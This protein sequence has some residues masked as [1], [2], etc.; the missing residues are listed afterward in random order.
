[1]NKKGLVKNKEIIFR[2]NSYIDDMQKSEGWRS[3][4]FF[5]INFVICQILMFVFKVFVFNKIGYIRVWFCYVIII[6]MLLFGLIEIVS[7]NSG[8]AS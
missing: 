2:E 4:E 8:F 3:I 1:M 7:L 6:F 5:V